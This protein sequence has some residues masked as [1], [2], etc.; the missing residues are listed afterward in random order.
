MKI[1]LTGIVLICSVVSA[2]SQTF[3]SELWHQGK[4]VLVTEDTI[5]GKIKYDLTRDFVQVKSHGKLLVYAASKILYFEIFDETTEDYRQ[6]YSIP[7]SHTGGYKSP[8]I[9]EVLFEGKMTLLCREEV[10]VVSAQSNTYSIR[11]GNYTYEVLVYNY[12]FLDHTG[13]IVKYTNKKKDLMEVLSK[14][15][16]QVNKYMKQRKLQHDKRVDLIRIVAF[17]NGMI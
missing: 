16:D 5:S 15:Y 2:W 4:I 9:F 12:Y 14:R 6:F 1:A 3:P 10:S 13:N 7:Y 11:G 8:V 17:Y